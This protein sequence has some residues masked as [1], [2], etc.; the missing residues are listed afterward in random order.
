MDVQ[1]AN[2]L[3]DVADLQVRN[4]NKYADA[5]QLAGKAQAALDL[6]VA[7][8]L[9]DLRAKKK[10]LGVDMAR[11]MLIGENSH[12]RHFYTE[13]MEN[14]AIHKGLEKVLDAGSTKI[15]FE[16]SVMKFVKEGEKY[17]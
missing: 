1:K 5:R 3:R 13:W 15:S 17:G 4:A 14:E 16:Q 10:N 6:M 9:D 11:L 8:K 2:A 7:A 12:A